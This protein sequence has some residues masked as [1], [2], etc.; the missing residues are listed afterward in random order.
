M[1]LN[2]RRIRCAKLSR[3]SRRAAEVAA[4]RMEHPAKGTPG[5]IGLLMIGKPDSSRSLSSKIWIN[6]WLAYLHN[7]YKSNVLHGWKNDR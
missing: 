4:L 3:D 1:T 2:I 7:S 6:L 5:G